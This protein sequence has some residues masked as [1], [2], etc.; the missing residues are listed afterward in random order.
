ME[1]FTIVE[2][3]G[4][5]SRPISTMRIFILNYKITVS[6]LKKLPTIFEANFFKN[7]IIA[8]AVKIMF[9]HKQKLHHVIYNIL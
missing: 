8:I 4:E 3:L 7:C 6:L 9:C 5:D 2:P 1:G